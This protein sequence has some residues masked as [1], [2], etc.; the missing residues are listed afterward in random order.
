MKPTRTANI[1][2]AAFCLVIGL[3]LIGVGIFILAK[4][5]DSFSG[6]LLIGMGVLV[7]VL[8]CLA[9]YLIVRYDK[10]QKEAEAQMDAQ[11]EKMR[12]F[13]ELKMKEAEQLRS[14][15]ERGE[16]N[17]ENALPDVG[18]AKDDALDAEKDVSDDD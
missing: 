12:A 17:A 15:A 5:I 13:I 2:L 7:C 4:G 8:F 10:I 1:I 9:T 14:K 6:G 3:A 18:R 11:K 16:N